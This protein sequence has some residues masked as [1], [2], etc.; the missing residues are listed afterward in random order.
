M[1]AVNQLNTMLA[2]YSCLLTIAVITASPS[3]PSSGHIKIY[4]P[5]EPNYPPINPFRKSAPLP[6]SDK[7]QS[8]LD[9]YALKF[10]TNSAAEEAPS[11]RAAPSVRLSS[12]MHPSNYNIPPPLAPSPQ[13]PLRIPSNSMHHDELVIANQPKDALAFEAISN[14]TAFFLQGAHLDKV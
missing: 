9:A 7:A 5:A 2:A 4:P 13:N 11:L 8:L 12:A 1:S 10:A 6:E 3:L 14:P